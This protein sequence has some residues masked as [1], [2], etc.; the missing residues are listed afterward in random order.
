MQ[1]DVSNKIL[2]VISVKAEISR[3]TLVDQRSIPLLPL[4]FHAHIFTPAC[5]THQFSITVINLPREQNVSV[6]KYP[7]TAVCAKRG[8]GK[9][10]NNQKDKVSVT[11]FHGV[12]IKNHEQKL[13]FKTMT[14]KSP[15]CSKMHQELWPQAVIFSWAQNMISS[16]LLAPHLVST[17]QA[18]TYSCSRTWL[19]CAEHWN[20]HRASLKSWIKSQL[21]L[22]TGQMKNTE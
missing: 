4:P 21:S 19:L 10:K 13:F 7:V 16:S 20:I 3:S 9:E 11:H 8:Q 5:K 17:R 1:S 12:L 15:V 6:L 18:S 22:N 2:E 14:N